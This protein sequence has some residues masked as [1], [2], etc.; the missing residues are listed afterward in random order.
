MKKTIEGLCAVIGA[1]VCAGLMLMLIGYLVENFDGYLVLFLPVFA[2]GVL[3]CLIGLLENVGM[4][5]KVA[6]LFADGK[7][8]S[9]E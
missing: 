3:I 9:H 8:D 1:F 6:N 7:E 2:M 4:T 5:D